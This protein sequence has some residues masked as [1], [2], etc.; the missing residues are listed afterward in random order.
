ML[1]N[2]HPQVIMHGVLLGL[3]LIGAFGLIMQSERDE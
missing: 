3:L 1:D 2:F